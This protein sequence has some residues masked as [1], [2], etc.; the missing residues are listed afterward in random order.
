MTFTQVIKLVDIND[1]TAQKVQEHIAGWDQHEAADAPGY[2]GATLQR[3]VETP[4]RYYIVVD[5]SSHEQAERNNQRSET[6]RWAEELS[7]LGTAEYVNLTEV[8]R[9]AR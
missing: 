5:F 3:D 2:L 4:G 8:Y 6:A 9:T 1:E 7:K